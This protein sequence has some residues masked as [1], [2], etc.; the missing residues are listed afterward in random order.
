MDNSDSKKFF[1]D[2]TFDVRDDTPPGKDPDSCSPTL[3]KYHQLLWSKDLP[4]GQKLELDDK[5]MGYMGN[6]QYWFSG[7]SIVHSF[8]RWAKY[9][10]IIKQID[11]AVIENFRHIGYTIGGDIIFPAN[12][13]AGKGKM[14]MNQRRGIL[15]KICDRFDLTLECIRRYYLG[16]DSP[17]YSCI[18][19]FKPFFDS[20]VDFK[21]YVDFFLLQDLVTDDYSGIKYWYP[22][23]G[24]FYSNPLPQTP[25]E[26][27]T[28][29]DTVLDF[30]AK[31]N[32]RI[33]QWAKENL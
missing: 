27:L 24:E 23:S 20:F 14:S 17:L 28:Y 29:V 6:T 7:D 33:D 31:R 16:T 3:R 10:H 4:C 25:E 8:S 2:T 12:V 22:F 30:L 1:I 18:C 11:P 19:D 32:A 21:G 9:Q 5:L 13:P 26:Y 15:V